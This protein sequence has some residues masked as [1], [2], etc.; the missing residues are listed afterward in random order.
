MARIF[1]SMES[2]DPQ[3]LLAAIKFLDLALVIPS[4]HFQFYQWMFI[5]DCFS[6]PTNIRE[7]CYK[8]YMEK[9]AATSKSDSET[10]NDPTLRTIRM[11]QQTLSN[12]RRPLIQLRSIESY[13]QLRPI[14]AKLSLHTYQNIIS[15][16]PP[17]FEFIE[18]ILEDDFIEYD[19]NT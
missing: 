2:T 6:A 9:L 11:P 5:V 4:E 13:E 17:D 19:T 18:Y 3:L 14:A 16:S 12:L 15:A 7:P 8:P 1:S 10:T